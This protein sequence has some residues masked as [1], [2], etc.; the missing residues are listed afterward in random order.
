[1]MFDF[2]PSNERDLTETV[3]LMANMANFVLADITEAKSIPQELSHII[4]FL[5]SVPVKPILFKED[6]GYA[7]FEHWQEY[8]SV[9][10]VFSYK[11]KQHL[12]SKLNI[13]VLKPICAWKNRQNET[14]ALKNENKELQ[15]KVKELQEKLAK[16]SN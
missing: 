6:Y 7:M 4:P 11:S 2:E 9:L 12:L 13:E 15:E 1:M 5:P 14:S 16:Q 8:Q 3:Q 10:P